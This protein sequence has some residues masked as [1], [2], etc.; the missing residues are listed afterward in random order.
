M[1]IISRAPACMC[2]LFPGASERACFSGTR[3]TVEQVS[4]GRKA[5][6]PSVIKESRGSCHSVG[7]QD[8]AR[9]LLAL[10]RGREQGREREQR[11]AHEG[12]TKRIQARQVSRPPCFGSC[13][14]GRFPAKQLAHEHALAGIEYAHGRVPGALNGLRALLAWSRG[15]ALARPLA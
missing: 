12:P 5:G 9:A 4:R 11:S 15:P 3:S 1:R 2:A 6:L 8:G 14:L 10:G 13:N 7:P